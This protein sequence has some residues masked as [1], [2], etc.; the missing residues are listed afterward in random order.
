MFER[1]SK[2][3]A[4][5][6][7]MRIAFATDARSL[8]PDQ[9]ISVMLK[10]PV[11]LLW[12]G[13]IGTY[14]KSF[15]ESNATVGDKANDSLRVDARDLRCKAIGEGGNLGMTQL[16]RIEYGLKGGVSFTDFIDNSAGVDCSDHE[17]NIKI[18]LNEV[19]NRAPARSEKAQSDADAKRSALLEGMTDEVSALVLANNYRQ[20]Q[21]L[22]LTFADPELGCKEFN[23]LIN[24]LETSAGLDREIEFLPS[25]EQLE[26]RASAHL[27]PTRPELAVA[28]SYMKMFL[29]AQ[30]VS[31]TYLNDPLLQKHLFKAFPG[32][33]VKRYAKAIDQHPLRSEL[34][35]TQL[36]NYLVNRV[37]AYFVFELIS[38]SSASP[39]RV[40]RASILAIEAFDAESQ[41]QSIESLDHSV[42]SSCQ[43]E[44]MLALV[45]LVRDGTRWLLRNHSEGRDLARE[46]EAYAHGV[47]AM[48]AMLPSGFPQN[49]ESRFV[50]KREAFVTSACP[51]SSQSP[52]LKTR[53]C[54]RPSV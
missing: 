20:V 10:A 11:D 28:T 30:L 22:A 23:D 54:R 39:A 37:G 14:V 35:A 24:F 33:L 38:S 9:L 49:I 44:M 34:M 29:K 2:S 45:K 48:C 13:G 3:I 26:Q 8:T 7:E 25:A 16:S 53:F 51:Q 5:T 47:K 41:W 36:A 40:V 1:S 18:L 32:S 19:A 46:I 17:V 43:D 6:D 50:K 15:S 31:A 27:A 12:N 42:A 21:T 4:L 52:S